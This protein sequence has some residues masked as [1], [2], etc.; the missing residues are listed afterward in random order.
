MDRWKCLE[1]SAS[2]PL[3]PELSLNSFDGFY[4]VREAH[5]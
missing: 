4:F 5:R 3:H 2:I 1:N